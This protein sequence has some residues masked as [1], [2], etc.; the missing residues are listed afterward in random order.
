MR[1]AIVLIA[2]LGAGVL[3]FGTWVG[4]RMLVSVLTGA[5]FAQAEAAVV[6]DPLV[7]GYRGDPAKALGLPFEEVT[8]QTD[9]GPAPAWPG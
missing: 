5:A 9:L 3:A 8:V 4:H 7:I 2:V 1:T 6:A